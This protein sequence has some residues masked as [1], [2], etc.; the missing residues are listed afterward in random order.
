[1]RATETTS[2]A[3]KSARVQLKAFSAS[4]QRNDEEPQRRSIFEGL[5][6]MLFLYHDPQINQTYTANSKY[7]TFLFTQNWKIFFLLRGNFAK[8]KFSSGEEPAQYVGFELFYFFFYFVTIF[9]LAAFNLVY[10]SR[11]TRLFFVKKNKQNVTENTSVFVNLNFDSGGTNSLKVFHKS[12]K[13]K[14]VL[15]N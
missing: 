9:T 10:Y 11:V 7:F 5:A 2:C 15:V 6:W 8:L 4:V 14:Q 13:V 12:E 1:M 3:R